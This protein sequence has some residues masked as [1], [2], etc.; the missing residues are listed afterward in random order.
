MGLHRHV[1]PKAGTPSIVRFYTRSTLHPSKSTAVCLDIRQVDSRRNLLFVIRNPLLKGSSYPHHHPF[2][3][4]FTRT[5]LSLLTTLTTICMMY[6]NFVFLSAMTAMASRAL[7]SSSVSPPDAPFPEQFRDSVLQAWDNSMIRFQ[8]DM[9][10]YSPE[11]Y[12][13]TAFDQVIDG[14]GYVW[15]ADFLRFLSWPRTD[16][17][18]MTLG[19]LTSAYDGTPTRP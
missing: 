1:Q 15:H 7:A 13:N 18:F 5:R 9:P 17:G 8:R 19:L 6:S 10:Q 16:S 2:L 11:I 12:E 3:L 14:N 4:C